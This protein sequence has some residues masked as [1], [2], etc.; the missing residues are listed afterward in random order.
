M[1]E[2]ALAHFKGYR[3]KRTKALNNEVPQRWFATD[4]GSI[5][6]LLE[7]IFGTASEN[8]EWEGLAK[9]DKPDFLKLQAVRI[10]IAFVAGCRHDLRSQFAIR[11]GHEVKTPIDFDRHGRSETLFNN[12]VLDRLKQ[13]VDTK[14]QGAKKQ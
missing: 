14:K 3:E 2:T 13:V 12:Y 7:D 1:F 4:A 8:A 6:T 11:P 9:S 5:P 10:K